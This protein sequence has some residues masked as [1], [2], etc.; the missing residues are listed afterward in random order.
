MNKNVLYIHTSPNLNGPNGSLSNEI[1]KKVIST[2]EKKYNINEINL[3]EDKYFWEPINSDNLKNYFDYRSDE[4]ID[5][6]VKTDILIIATP[7]IN[8]SIP[9]ILKNYFDRVLQANK[10]FKYKY[11]KGKGKS[12]GLLPEGKKAVIINT[13]GSPEDWYPFT[14]TSSS[15]EGI[16]KFIGIENVKKLQIFGT[17][18][19]DFITKKYH[20]I[21]SENSEKIESIID[22]IEK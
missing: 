2:I 12:V 1:A 14:S 18:T 9:G 19:P 21:I 16:L 8:F 5:Q 13:Q 22:F 6:L 10:T 4:L 15:I 7:T 20:E 3:D 11:D 17:K